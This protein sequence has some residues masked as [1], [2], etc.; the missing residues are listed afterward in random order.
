MT[1]TAS[2]ILSV[3]IT[4]SEREMLEAAAEQTRTSLSDFVRRSA[5]EAAELEMM[6]RTIIKIPAGKWHEIE[7]WMNEPAKELPG[8]R[9]LASITPIWKK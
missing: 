3:R 4:P 9:R 8:M 5:V 1:E 6:E 2:S 7:V